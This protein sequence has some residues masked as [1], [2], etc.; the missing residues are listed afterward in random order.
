M[1]GLAVGVLSGL[2]GYLITVV[3][4]DE[5]RTAF[6]KSNG[7][8]TPPCPG[9]FEGFTK[10]TNST[11]GFTFIPPTNIT[12][13]TVTDISGLGVTYT[14]AIVAVRMRDFT[15]WCGT[16]AVTFPVSST[17]TYKFTA[18]IKSP[19]P[20]PTNGQTLDFDVIWN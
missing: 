5:V 19:I 15:A 4:A 17:D 18:Y 8:L 20:P 6:T 11:G 9:A 3:Q 10:L 7:T 12:S 2:A 13:C 16:N 14:S 1:C